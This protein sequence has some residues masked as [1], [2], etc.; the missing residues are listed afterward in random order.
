MIKFRMKKKKNESK[1]KKMVKAAAEEAGGE[2][3]ELVLTAGVKGV[4]RFF[5]HFLNAWQ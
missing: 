4:L 5:Q 3:A 2:I 1:G